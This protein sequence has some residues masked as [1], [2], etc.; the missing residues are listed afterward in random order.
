MSKSHA[1]A[2]VPQPAYPLSGEGPAEQ[3]RNALSVLSVAETDAQGGR[4]LTDPEYRAVRA[5]LE[6]AIAQLEGPRV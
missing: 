4:R 1:V 3:C 6:R 5:R 2:P